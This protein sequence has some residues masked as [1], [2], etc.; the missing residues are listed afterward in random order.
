MTNAKK[1]T[2]RAIA[3]FCK[4]NEMTATVVPCPENTESHRVIHALPAPTPLASI[5]IP[6]RDR[7]GLLKRC[8]E[9]IRARTD[10][11]PFEI[12]VVDNGSIE[13]ET[14]AFLRQGEADKSIRV[15]G[16]SGPF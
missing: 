4:R 2:L 13:E 7:V 8:V 11:E 1:G 14:R 12:V 9:S 10:Y 15:I 16:D 3:Y 6:T 5:I